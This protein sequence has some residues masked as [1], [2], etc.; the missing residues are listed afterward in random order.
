MYSQVFHFL[1]DFVNVSICL[2]LD[3]EYANINILNCICKQTVVVEFSSGPGL[4]NYVEQIR[5][6]NDTMMLEVAGSAKIEGKL[7]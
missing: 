2:F 7:E 3:H 1:D 4:N 6:E 5:F